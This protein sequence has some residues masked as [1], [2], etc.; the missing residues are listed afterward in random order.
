M[1]E[2][3][4]LWQLKGGGFTYSKSQMK[5]LDHL[6]AHP[7]AELKQIVEAMEREDFPRPAIAGVLRSKSVL[8]AIRKLKGRRVWNS[9]KG[10]LE[11]VG[12]GLWDTAKKFIPDLLGV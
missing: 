9:V 7:P 4:I 8:Q 6:I 1:S 11:K 5:V 12:K 2:L 10:G 3:V